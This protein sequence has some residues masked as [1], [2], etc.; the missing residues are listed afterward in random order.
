MAVE[1]TSR[2]RMLAAL[3]GGKPDHVPMAFMIFS[4]L[5]ERLAAK[6]GFEDPAASIEA[7]VALG[8]DTVVDLRMFAP[9]SK[10]IG[11]NDARGF[12]VRFAP[13]VKTRQ[14][15]EV[16]SDHSYPVLHKEYITPSG[17]LSIAVDQTEDWPYGDAERGDF[18]VPFMDDY[19]APRAL[20][21]LLENRL[22]LAAMRHLLASPTEE[23]VKVTHAAWDRGK[24]LACKHD[25]LLAGGWGVGADALAWFCGLQ[26][27]VMMAMDDPVFLAD[28]LGLISAWNKQRMRAYLEYGVDLF[29]RRA[30]YE[31]TELWSPS[32]FRQFF[33]PII[34]EE[35]RMAREA[36][37]KYGYILTSGSMPLHDML[38]ELDIDVLIGPDPVQGKGTNLK[39][40]S[41]QLRGKI[42]T[43]GGVNGFITVEQGTPE[44]IDTA[45]REAI[46][47]LGPEG[48]ILSPVDNVS[49]PS[50]A[51][52]KNVLS[53]IES[54]KKYR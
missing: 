28:I 24:A 6:H 18:N 25:L 34:R 2:E 12:P 51:V 37:V 23:D 32:L 3:N 9:E 27:A 14:W 16:S 20:K 19:L 29:I 5:E 46:E 26:N 33:F 35:V 17:R 48:F 50:D 52:W 36:G 4:A 15:A 13:D 30:W 42:P 54:W 47:T 43:W 8:V 7:Q 11:H 22:D 41:E 45:V 1:M 21:H 31:G 39:C 44:G 38:I 53:M 49:D 10:E 40:M